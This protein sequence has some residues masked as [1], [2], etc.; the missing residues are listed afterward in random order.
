MGDA[1][2]VCPFHPDDYHKRDASASDRGCYNDQSGITER[3]HERK[4]CLTEC[5]YEYRRC[6]A[7]Y[8]GQ[9]RLMTAVDKA[10]YG[11][12]KRHKTGYKGRI[13]DSDSQGMGDENIVCRFQP[14]DYDIRCPAGSG[15]GHHSDQSVF[16]A[17]SYE[18]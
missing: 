12:E 5:N 6:P 16:A 1:N 18:F 10:H 2:I 7:E 4:L 17:A 14:D 3:Y 13:P 8:P 15:R 11:E 9:A